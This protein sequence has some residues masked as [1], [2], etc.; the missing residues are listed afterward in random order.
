MAGAIAD[1]VGR[2]P[3]KT[4]LMARWVVLTL[5][6]VTILFAAA[7]LLTEGPAAG[8]DNG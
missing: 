4:I 6:T 3:G 1:A 5:P 8:A 7:R 2:L